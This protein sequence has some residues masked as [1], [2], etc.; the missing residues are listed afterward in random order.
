MTV[1]N[2]HGL[3]GKKALVTGGTTGIGRAAV[4]LLHRE[5]ARVA[6][7][8]SNADTLAAAR[9]ELPEDVLV[10]RSDARSAADASELSATL[11][12]RFGELD[13]VFLNAGIALLSPFEAITEQHYAEQFDVNVKG[14]IFT[15]H[16]LL[17]LLAPGASVIVCTSVADQRGTAG[18]SVYSATKGAVAALVRAL[19]VELAPRKIRVNS[20]SP[21]TIATPIQQKFGLPADV[22]SAVAERYTQRIPLGRFG[23]AE[24]VAS[25]VL[26]LASPASSY[27]TGIELV[28]DGGLSAT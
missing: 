28:V 14:V 10:L 1:S 15:L 26:F 21:A 6:L 22:A 3:L 18:L 27:V 9:R 5:G 4:E 2:N 7:T 13:V 23:Q 12:E 25:A 16:R 24:E 17:P 11:G 20:V 19:A 8:G